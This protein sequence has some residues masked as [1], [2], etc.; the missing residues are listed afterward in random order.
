[1]QNSSAQLIDGKKIAQTI[2]QTFPKRLAALPYVP[3]LADIIVGDDAV[4]LSYVRIKNRTAQKHGL[5]F[6][7]EQLPVHAS[8]EQIKQALTKIQSMPNM[9]GV[10]IQLPMPSHINQQ[11]VLAELQANLDVDCIGQKGNEAFYEGKA[12]WLPPTAGAIWEILQTLPHNFKS[13]KIAVIG[14]G[15]LVGKPITY[16]LQQAGCQVD[17][18]TKE[19]DN[20]AE[21]LQH[22][23]IIISGTGQAGLI[24]GKLIKPGAVVI[25]A[26]TSESGGGIV[27]DVDRDSV[28]GVAS[29]LSPVPG[30]VGPVTVAKLLDNVLTAAEQWQA[31]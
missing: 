27:G 12:L 17:I 23:D 3:V 16:L 4:A 13:S 24:T 7:T 19:N 6:H 10:I 9:R 15:E 25:D 8:T 26:G 1:M 30:G 29:M 20:L 22:A 28:S 5:A 11:E 14:Q 31:K 21:V 18:A 2:F